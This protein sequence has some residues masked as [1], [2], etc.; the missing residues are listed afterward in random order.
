MPRT[1]AISCSWEMGLV[2]GCLIISH[3]AEGSTEESPFR[4]EERCVLVCRARREWLKLASCECRVTGVFGRG[5]SSGLQSWPPVG[6]LDAA[7]RSK[8]LMLFS[9]ERLRPGVGGEEPRCWATE[10]GGEQSFLLPR[11]FPLVWFSSSGSSGH[12]SPS[13]SFTAAEALGTGRFLVGRSRPVASEDQ[14]ASLDLRGQHQKS[15]V[16]DRWRG[17]HPVLRDGWTWHDMTAQEKT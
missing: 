8:S 10:A 7:P 1:S 14:V 5:S 6:R 4:G 2:S 11:R 3:A 9:L 15:G 17:R 16:R 12:S 13:A